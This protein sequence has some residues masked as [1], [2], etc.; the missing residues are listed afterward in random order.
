[1]NFTFS[2]GSG[3]HPWFIA[4]V[5]ASIAF[6]MIRSVWKKAAEEKLQAQATAWP[7][8]RARI[9][10][11]QVIKVPGNENK[12][13]SWRGLVTYSY[14]GRE[15]QIGEFD[16]VFDDEQVADAW[17]ESLKGETVTVHVD[18]L[19]ETQSRWLEAQSG[20]DKAAD[21]ERYGAIAQSDLPFAMR[22]L[23]AVT[24]AVA[25]A[26][27]L[28]SI[29]AQV[30]DLYDVDFLQPDAHAAAFFSMHIAA[31]VSAIAAAAVFKARFP[32]LNQG[33]G[34]QRLSKPM[35]T[36]LIKTF[37]V[38][39]TGVF[40]WYWAKMFFGLPGDPVNVIVLMFSSIWLVFFTSSA[41]YAWF[42][43]RGTSDTQPAT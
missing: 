18:P 42:A 16:Y 3:L 2:A 25:G 39:G 11:A 17:A 23:A 40:L 35:V 6:T 36:N 34:L 30:A 22:A 32:K 8:T 7:T 14:I 31:I 5:V 20:I 9:V 43:F 29:G 41:T 37:S 15:T 1:V 27:A 26:G 24:V 12:D 19:D 21:K 13:V 28:I 10:A 38:Y 33:T 4:A